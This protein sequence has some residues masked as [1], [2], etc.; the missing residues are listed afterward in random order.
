MEHWGRGL[1]PKEE[2]AFAEVTNLCKSLEDTAKK[3]GKGV[4]PSLSKE[5]QRR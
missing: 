2:I 3:T 5:T 4:N 1:D